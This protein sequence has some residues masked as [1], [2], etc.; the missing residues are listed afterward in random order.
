MLHNTVAQMLTSIYVG[1]AYQHVLHSCGRWVCKRGRYTRYIDHKEARQKER[2]CD[3]AKT[4]KL[5]EETETDDGNSYNKIVLVV[6][7][8]LI[9]F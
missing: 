5:I 7:N 2:G 6:I 9:Y 4:Y 3:I 8:T 1:L